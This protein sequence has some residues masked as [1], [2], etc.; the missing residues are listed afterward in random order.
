MHLHFENFKKTNSLKILICLF[1]SELITDLSNFSKKIENLINT[2]A[3][4]YFKMLK[5]DFLNTIFRNPN[6]VS[7]I[8]C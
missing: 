2:G 8:F 6:V 4:V 7:F 3:I 5:Y 1:N